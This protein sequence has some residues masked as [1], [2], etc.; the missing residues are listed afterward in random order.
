MRT[1]YVARS[2]EIAARRL[3]DEMVVMSGRDSTLFT[4][5]EVAAA[6]WEAADGVTPL[7]EIVERAVCATY[8]VAPDEAQSDAER[9]VDDLAGH[10]IMIV[11]DRPIE[12]K[13][14]S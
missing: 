5:N 10:G 6:I 1:R 3:G 13:A 4:L 8:E 14:D 2:R 9:L 7:A 11:S 12:P